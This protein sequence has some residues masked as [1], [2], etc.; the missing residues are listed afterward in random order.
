MT[1]RF[2]LA[3]TIFIGVVG[4]L[5]FIK[6]Q[7][8][9]AGIAIGASFQPP[10]ETVT[11]IT[12]REEAWQETLVTVG[13]FT[14]VQG[15]T[16]SA[17]EEG[18]ITGIL[19][20]SGTKVEKGAVLVQLDVSVEEAELKA[21]VA[22]SEN[23][24]VQL[25]RLQGLQGTGALAQKELDDADTEWR[26]ATA[27]G[28]RLRAVIDRK[29]I[30]APFGGSTG[31]RQ[32]QLGQYLSKGDP[33]VNL[34]SLSPIYIEFNI[35]QQRLALL[36]PGQRVELFVDAYPGETFAGTITTISPQLD[37]ATRNLQL[38]ATVAN[39]DERLRPGMFARVHVLVG[40]QTPRITVPA[41]A[42]NSA[43]FGDSVFI[44]EKMTD[45]AGQEYLGVRQQF[46][47]VGPA[48]GDQVAI[49]EGLQAGEEVATSGLFKLRPNA[50]VKIDNS[51]TPGNSATPKPNDS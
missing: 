28:E 49:L 13:A 3:L 10:P 18:K 19:F 26:Q 50:A 15:V 45:A 38:Q 22:R 29:T 6:Y 35:P 39:A 21:A 2:I 17:E 43:P 37:T 36:N 11:S 1:L 46:V 7:Q 42:V 31:I 40:G 27:E 12:A 25:R 4:G 8:I 51:I 34:Q 41:T 30:R 48:R 23:A 9:Q 32:V 47:R 16:V 5:G 24:L 14:P 20:E 44:L 33:I